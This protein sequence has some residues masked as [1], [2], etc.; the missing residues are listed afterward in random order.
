MKRFYE[1]LFDWD[2]LVHTLSKKSGHCCMINKHVLKKYDENFMKDNQIATKMEIGPKERS[3]L[4]PRDISFD[5]YCNDRRYPV[6]DK[7]W[8]VGRSHDNHFFLTKQANV[9][10]CK[11]TCQSYKNFTKLKLFTSDLSFPPPKTVQNYGCFP[12]YLLDM[13]SLLPILALRIQP[14]DKVLDMCASPGGKTVAMK[15]FISESGLLVSNDFEKRRYKRLV[16]VS[17]FFYYISQF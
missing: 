10:S 11:N 5:E 15:Q 14:G 8:V 17:T 9:D 12:Y 2:I 6:F 1:K 16:Q 3:Y 13:S 7:L 4:I